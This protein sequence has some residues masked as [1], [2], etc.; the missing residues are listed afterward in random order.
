MEVP[1]ENPLENYKN[2]QLK[3]TS[4][5]DYPRRRKKGCVIL[6]KLREDV[7]PLFDAD[8]VIAVYELIGLRTEVRLNVDD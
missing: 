2:C 5:G 1:K 4:C 8:I 6:K 3:S 7:G